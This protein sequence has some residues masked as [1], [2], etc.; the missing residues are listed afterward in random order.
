[1]SSEAPLPVPQPNPV[2]SNVNVD[3]P[4]VVGTPAYEVN[5]GGTPQI[6][7]TPQA[8]T[9]V[10][11]LGASSTGNDIYLNGGVR[12]NMNNLT[13]MN[14]SYAVSDNDYLINVSSSTYSSLQ[15]PAAATRAGKV[16][17]IT[18]K[19]GGPSPLVLSPNGADT[20]DGETSVSMPD[21]NF[22]V[23]I[24]SDGVN[25]WIPF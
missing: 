20:L 2:N 9:T 10:I 6:Q 4:P 21:L 1:M 17:I 11:T 25:T 23:Q 13:A 19:F 5:V 22:K 8:G 3:V 15:L 18:R 16:F 24:M 7:I 12:Y 14:A